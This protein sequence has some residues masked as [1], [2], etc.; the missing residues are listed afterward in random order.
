MERPNMRELRGEGETQTHNNMKLNNIILENAHIRQALMA[1]DNAMVF[2]DNVE[3]TG[4]MDVDDHD[5]Y[6]E[7]HAAIIEHM[8]KRLNELSKLALKTI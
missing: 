8:E 6:I 2:L 1:M 3:C 5:G 7:G 4:S